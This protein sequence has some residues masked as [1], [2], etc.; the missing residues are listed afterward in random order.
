MWYS[1]S[2][3]RVKTG[4]FIPSEINTIN[5]TGRGWKCS[6]LIMKRSWKI[7]R[8]FHQGLLWVTL[9]PIY[10]WICHSPYGSQRRVSAAFSLL[11]VPWSTVF[12]ASTSVSAFPSRAANSLSRPSLDSSLDSTSLQQSTVSK[13]SERL[14]F[15][16]SQCTYNS[17]IISSC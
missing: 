9:Q 8:H 16:S 14:L 4:L 17:T 6:I 1:F 11:T 7:H 15:L 13:V 2:T 12:S 10:I 3:A 5:K